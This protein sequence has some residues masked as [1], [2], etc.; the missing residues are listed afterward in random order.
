MRTSEDYRA[1]CRKRYAQNIEKERERG[2][3]KIEVYRRKYPERVAE[4]RRR[5]REKQT[6]EM[7]KRIAA[8]SR[9]ALLLRLAAAGKHLETPEEASARLKRVWENRTPEERAKINEALHSP[10]AAANRRAAQHALGENYPTALVWNLRAPDGRTFSFRNLAGFIRTHRELFTEEQ[11]LPVNKWG[12]TRIESA[13]SALSPRR[14]RV[15]EHCCGWSW[16]VGGE[17]S[18]PSI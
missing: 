5:S 1:Y 17:K 4:Q 15:V 16:N 10:K 3:K 8:Q 7:K 13:I 14:K 2:R 11:L 6:P 18:M 12:R 9:Q